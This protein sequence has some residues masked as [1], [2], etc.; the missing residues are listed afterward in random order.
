MEPRISIV[1]IGT[2]D[3]PRALRFYRDGLGFP[4]RAV[5][6]DPIA[7]FAT[8]GSRLALYPV[9]KLAED[10]GP[11]VPVPPPGFGGITLAHNVRSREEVPQ[12]L[13]Q[14]ERAGGRILKPAQDTFWGGHHGYFADPEGYAWEV[15]WGPM[16]SFDDRGELQID[17]N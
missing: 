7:F 13:A 2:R 4:T 16:F 11:D 9:D 10:I 8:G 17:G 1:S 5:E 15:A 6:T 3:F 12:V 14:A